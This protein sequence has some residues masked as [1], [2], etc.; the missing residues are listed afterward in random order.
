MISNP[1]SDLGK[2]NA[3]LHTQFMIL[4]ESIIQDGRDGVL[5]RLFEQIRN[6]IP[7]QVNQTPFKFQ[8]KSSTSLES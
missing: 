2:S 4:S 5:H 8:N 7:K 6:M 1:D 3:P